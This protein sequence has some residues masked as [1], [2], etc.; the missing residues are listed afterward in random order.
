MNETKSLEAQLK[1]MGATP[2]LGASLRRGCSA[3]QRNTPRPG[4]FCLAGAGGG[5]PAAGVS[6]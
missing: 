5:V 1:I 4:C 3:G 2:P 6:V